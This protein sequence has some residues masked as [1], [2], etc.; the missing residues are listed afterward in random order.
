MRENFS[1]QKDLPED[2]LYPLYIKG[3]LRGII[4]DIWGVG[5]AFM[6]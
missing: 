4:Q 1:I 5:K 6:G 2:P 3:D